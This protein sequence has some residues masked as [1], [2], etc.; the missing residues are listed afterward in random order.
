MNGQTLCSK[1]VA[2][3]GEEYRATIKALKEN[4]YSKDEYMGAIL[5]RNIARDEIAELSAQTQQGIGQ[6]PVV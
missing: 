2:K 5:D 4:M 6:Q 1:A 3:Q